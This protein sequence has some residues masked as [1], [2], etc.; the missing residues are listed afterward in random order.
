M[1]PDLL[2]LIRDLR[3]WTGT[4]GYISQGAV[5]E[6]VARTL[7]EL[8]AEAT[9]LLAQLEAAHHPAPTQEN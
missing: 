8:E 3:G 6:A 9:D 5:D 1:K 2:Q 4:P 7:N